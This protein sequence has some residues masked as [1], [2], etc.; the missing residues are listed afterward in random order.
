MPDSSSPFVPARRSGGKPD[1]EPR[2][3]VLIHRQY[4]D[5]WDSLV[6][7]VGMASAQQFWDHVAATPGSP[8]PINRA[9]LLK[10]KAHQPI[11]P[12][13][14]RTVHYEIAGAGRLNYQFC[15][16]FE[17]GTHGDPQP[18]VFILTI[19]LGSH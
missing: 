4:V 10:G 1:R 18:V 5:A 17:G 3:R 16:A 11:A 7:R 15:D 13:F 9:S 6:V 2:Y 14:S 12:G 8:P 19:N